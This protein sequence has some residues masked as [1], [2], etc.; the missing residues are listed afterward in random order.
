MAI[1]RDFLCR[2]VGKLYGLPVAPVLV[3]ARLILVSVRGK[4]P[5][6]GRVLNFGKWLIAIVVSEKIVASI[7]NVVNRIFRVGHCERVCM[8]IRGLL[9]VVF[10]E[11]WC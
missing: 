1:H 5:V 7:V 11:D 10:L 2:L 6:A 8:V 3:L 9:D 4:I